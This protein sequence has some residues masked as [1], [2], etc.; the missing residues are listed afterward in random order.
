MPASAYDS[1]V[2][3]SSHPTDLSYDDGDPALRFSAFRFSFAPARRLVA[4]GA[5]DGPRVRVVS[6]EA[7]YRVVFEAHADENPSQGWLG[8][9][10]IWGVQFAGDKYLLVHLHRGGRGAIAPTDVHEVY[11]AATWR[12]VATIKDHAMS[13]LTLSPDGR[14]M[15]YVGGTDLVIAPFTAPP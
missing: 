15:A 12:K 3:A 4:C 2:A 6:L 9:W 1:S 11:D 8:L 14:M 13:N 5:F 7:P 10:N